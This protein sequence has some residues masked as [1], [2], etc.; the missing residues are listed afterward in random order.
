MPPPA[1]VYE[2]NRLKGLRVQKRHVEACVLSFPTSP[3]EALDDQVSLLS[4]TGRPLQASV[5]SQ[6]RLSGEVQW[7]AQTPDAKEAIRSAT[8][9]A[10]SLEAAREKTAVVGNTAGGHLAVFAAGTCNREE[11][12][13]K[14]GT[15]EVS[16]RLAAC[17]AYY[18]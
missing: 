1:C 8:A 12:E 6:Y 3:Q 2:V 18:P 10:R 14:H 16:T 5:S 11:V 15:P 9:N 7:P 13:G 17:C 4:D